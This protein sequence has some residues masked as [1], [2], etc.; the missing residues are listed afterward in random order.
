[1][2]CDLPDPDS[3]VRTMNGAPAR[4]APAPVTRRTPR[5]GG[6]FDRRRLIIFPMAPQWAIEPLGKLPRRMVPS[7]PQQ[8]VTRGHLD[9]DGDITPWRH[10]HANQR[11]AQTENLMERIVQAK[12]L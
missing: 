10:R 8:L 1:M 2:A 12:A 11:H 6:F 7:R 4:R 3:P 5:R 9:Q